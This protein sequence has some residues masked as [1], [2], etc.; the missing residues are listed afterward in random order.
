MKMAIYPQRIK[1]IL[2]GRNST[3]LKWT[4]TL[5]FVF[6][7]DCNYKQI[8]D[9]FC[10]MDRN[11]QLTEAK[12]HGRLLSCLRLSFDALNPRIKENPSKSYSSACIGSKNKYFSASRSVTHIY[13]QKTEASLSITKRVDWRNRCLEEDNRAHDDHNT[14]YTIADRVGNRRYSLQYHVRNLQKSSQYPSVKTLYVKN[15]WAVGM[16]Q[17]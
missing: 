10:V 8:I 12:F 4:K 16:A 1:V 15:E 9:G 7:N 17:V 14:L 2:K 6:Y 3:K 13:K 5:Q 11:Y